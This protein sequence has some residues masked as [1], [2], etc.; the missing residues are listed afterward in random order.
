MPPRSKR[1]REQRVKSSE[2]SRGKFRVRVY[3]RSLSLSN[4]PLDE[5]IAVFDLNHGKD[6]DDQDMEE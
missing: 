6:K 4:V 3:S 1:K 5:L 2:G